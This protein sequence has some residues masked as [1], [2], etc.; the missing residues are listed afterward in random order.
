MDIQAKL[1]F[2]LGHYDTFKAMFG[3]LATVPLDVIKTR[4]NKLQEHDIR[5]IENVYDILHRNPK[6][7]K[8]KVTGH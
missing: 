7:L 6:M 1:D 3:E 2:I 5:I 4:R 8:T